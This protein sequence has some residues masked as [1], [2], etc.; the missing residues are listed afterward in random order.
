MSD[1]LHTGDKCSR[2][3]MGWS[4]Q[5]VGT[6]TLLPHRFRGGQARGRTKSPCDHDYSALAKGSLVPSPAASRYLPGGTREA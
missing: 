5:L 2:P 6:S 1:L 4:R 3:R